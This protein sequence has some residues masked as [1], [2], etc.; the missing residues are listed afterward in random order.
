MLNGCP[1]GWLM[2]F[3]KWSHVQSYSHPY[4]MQLSLY[5]CMYQVTPGDPYNS[6][7][8]HYDNSTHLLQVLLELFSLGLQLQELCMHL[9]LCH[10]QH[11]H[12][13]L[14]LTHHVFQP[15][16]S[17]IHSQQLGRGQEMNTAKATDCQDFCYKGCVCMCVCE[18]ACIHM[19]IYG[20]MCMCV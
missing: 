10:G 12:T 15:A 4:G 7:G 18:H 9:F 8:G 16:P 3:F 17:R 13:A 1:C 11:G 20:L 2:N 6:A 19:H 14:D 5:N